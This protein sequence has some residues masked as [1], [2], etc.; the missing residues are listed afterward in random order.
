LCEPG[1]LS[2]TLDVAVGRKFCLPYHSWD[3][4]QGE[5]TPAALLEIELPAGT[6]AAFPAAVLKA[7]ADEACW[8]SQDELEL[9]LA[10]DS[11]LKV[12]GVRQQG[13][14]LPRLSCQLLI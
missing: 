11:V 6:A 14:G 3:Y 10:R 9:L 7:R 2:V 4:R 5:G 13:S 8:R 12:T 1:F